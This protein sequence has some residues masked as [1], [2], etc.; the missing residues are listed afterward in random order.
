MHLFRDPDFRQLAEQVHTPAE[1]LDRLPKFEDLWR[2]PIKYTPA[3]A[4]ELARLLY[5][6]KTVC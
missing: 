4:V 1:H 6:K 2:L 5:E 3:K